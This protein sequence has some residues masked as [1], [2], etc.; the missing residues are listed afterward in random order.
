MLGAIPPSPIHFHGGGVVKHKEEFTLA[1]TL[2][3]ARCRCRDK[4][5]MILVECLLT[6]KLSQGESLYKNFHYV[7]TKRGNIGKF[8]RFRPSYCQERWP[9]YSYV[10]MR[11]ENIGNITFVA[12]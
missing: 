5:P 12:K 1:F 9:M 8:P 10:F 11:M 7:I 6:R 4:A 2:N 3:V